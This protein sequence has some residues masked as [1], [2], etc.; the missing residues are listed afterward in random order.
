MKAYLQHLITQAIHQLHTQDLL[1]LEQLP[2]I[3]LERTRDARH[4]DFA[5]NAAMVLAK[6]AA[7]PPRTLAE[8]IM[9]QLPQEDKLIARIEIAGPGFINFFLSPEAYHATIETILTQQAAYGRSQIGEQQQVLIEF[10]SANPTG[11]LHVGH[12]RGAAY[13]AALANL[14]TTAGFQVHREYYVNDAGRQMDI[15][16]VSIWLRYL[17]LGGQ[18][19]VFPSNG[20][21]GDYIWDIA[22][23]LHRE[24]GNQW[25]HPEVIE[26][27]VATEDSEAYLDSL[28]ACCKQ[29]LGDEDYQL[30]FQRGLEV[31]LADIQRDLAQFGV[32]YDNWFSER[33][34]KAQVPQAIERLSAQGHTYEHQGALWFRSSAFGDEKDRVLIRE[35]GQFTYFATDIAYHFN[36]LERGFARLINIWGADHHGYVARVKA[37]ITALGANAER[38]TVLL[39][40]FASLYRGQQRLQMSTRSGEFVTLRALRTEVGNDAA[41]FFYSQ[42]KSEQHLN[43]DLELA[44]SQS[45]DNPVYYIQYAHARIASVFRQ[46]QENQETWNPQAAELSCLETEAEHTLLVTLSRYPETIET[47]ALAY[48]PHQVTYYLRELAYHFHTFYVAH[49]ILV[50]DETLRQARLSLIAAVAQVLR[51]G[52]TL[53]GVSAPKEM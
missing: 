51:N 22:A 43:F 20:Y 6:A 17:E 28:I 3:T 36:K 5:C 7:M 46:L 2:T 47:A 35:N 45:Q 48:E 50:A 44:Q 34:L 13:G 21:Q 38:L 53:I 33:S 4:G 49:K 1:T 24:H 31:I 32:E 42:R 14:L 39:V 16:T 8:H 37:A 9:A 19:I 11:P 18:P 30:I 23:S 12:G 40:Q 15:L 26:P 27:I 41:R 10:V 52:L 29:L 25:Y